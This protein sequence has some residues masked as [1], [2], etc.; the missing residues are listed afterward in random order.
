LFICGANKF[1]LD[2]VQIQTCLI[3][4]NKMHFSLLISSIN[5]SFS[6]HISNRLTIHH[7]KVVTVYAAY[8]INH[9]NTI[10]VLL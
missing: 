9:V 1:S 7:Q 6:L 2:N 10:R 5:L 3:K 8:G 4:A